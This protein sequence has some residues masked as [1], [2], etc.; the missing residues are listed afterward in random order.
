M[1]NKLHVEL[2]A[3]LIKKAQDHVDHIFKNGSAQP[4]ASEKFD[5]NVKPEWYDEKR[6]KNAQKLAQSIFPQ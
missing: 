6:F 2:T 4:G 3:D 1:T 5:S